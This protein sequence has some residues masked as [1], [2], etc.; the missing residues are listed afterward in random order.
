VPAQVE[1]VIVDTLLGGNG[2]HVEVVGPR[3]GAVVVG[4]ASAPVPLRGLCLD[5]VVRSIGHN[6]PKGPAP[7]EA[8]QAMG[9]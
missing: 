8:I 6:L 1:T 9:P 7:S 2:G 4:E 3:P 5:L